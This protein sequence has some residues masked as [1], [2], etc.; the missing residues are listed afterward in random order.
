[1]AAGW[2]NPP[3]LRVPHRLE[4][5]VREICGYAASDMSPG[6]HRGLPSRTLTLV[7]PI[8]DP[9][10]TAPSWESLEAGDIDSQHLVLGGLHTTTAVILQPRTW[11]GIQVAVSPLGARALFGAPAAALPTG[12]WD[13]RDLLGPVVDQVSERLAEAPDWPTRYA[14]VLELFDEL[15]RRSDGGRSVR[16]EVA[17]GWRLLLRS[18]G[19]VGVADLARQVGL[20]PRRLSTLFAAELGLT[21]KVAARL[22]RFDS[23]RIAVARSA[24]SRGTSGGPLDLAGIA[25][26]L[27]YFDHAHLVREFTAFAGLSPSAWVG[28]EFRNV[29]AGVELRTAVSTA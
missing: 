16:P 4:A 15:L 26:E 11:A 23:A 13:A 5:H 18:R 29:Q 3:P 7:L 2:S 12:R 25:A 22:A 14:V 20:S 21:P 19:R 27:G 9:L 24:V 28:E 6:V 17:Q 8:G 10:R 1:M